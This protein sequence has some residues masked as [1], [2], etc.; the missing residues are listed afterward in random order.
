MTLRLREC[1]TCALLVLLTGLS[2]GLPACAIEPI[3]G[4]RIAS[5]PPRPTASYRVIECVI[6]N[7]QKRVRLDKP[8]WYHV[9]ADAAGPLIFEKGPTGRVVAFE[10]RWTDKLGSHALVWV[11]GGRFGYHIVRPWDASRPAERLLW[12]RKDLRQ[13]A[14]VWKP[15]PMGVPYARCP[16]ELRKSAGQPVVAPRRPPAR[17]RPAPR[18]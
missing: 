18:P 4:G 2:G 12:R 1:A 5:M 3:G 11:H 14:D 7:S 6:V 16:M 8:I 13:V 17:K 9:G 10:N 15:R